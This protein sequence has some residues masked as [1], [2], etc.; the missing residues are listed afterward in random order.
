M[1]EKRRCPQC[2]A[3]VPED[4]AEGLC[5]KCLLARAVELASPP[6]AAALP[7]PSPGAASTPDIPRYRIL[8][9]LGAG[10][11]GS[12]Y[13]AEQLQPHRTVALKVIKAGLASPEMLRRFSHEGEVLGRLQHPGIA[14]IYEAGTADTGH[15]P[16][17]FFAM[18]LVRGPSGEKAPSLIDFANRKKLDAR[19]RLELLAKV[20]DAVHY[21]HQKGIIHRDLKPANILVDES[22]QPKIL[23]FGV[24][25]VTDADLKAVTVQTDIGQIIGTLPYMAPEQAGG[26]PAQLDTRSDVYSLGV[27]G[28]ELLAGRLPYALKTLMIHEA[29][30]VIREEEP[31][32]LSLISKTFRGDIE[33]IVA[34][35]LAKEKERRYQSAAELAADARRYL[36]DEPIMARPASARYQMGK[37]ARRNKPLVGGVVAVFAVLV[38]GI[39]ATGWQAVRATRAE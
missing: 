38:V 36:A 20:A 23:D 4:A 7:V 8:R 29:V 5:P 16:Q 14:P 24:A 1:A 31:S 6:T 28:Y 26:D 27:I 19:Q 35:A 18:E 25:R 33:T 12:V 10:G 3:E 34:K 37:F 32:R 2:G 39:A 11:M 15:G 9:L 17:P 21:A 13:Q 30:R 22:G